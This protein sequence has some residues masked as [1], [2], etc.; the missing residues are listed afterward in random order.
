M[1]W[2]KDPNQFLVIVVSETRWLISI[3]KEILDTF[4]P[5]KK[6]YLD[7]HEDQFQIKMKI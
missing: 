3:L 6:F 7:K 1:G 2:H 4:A 5:E